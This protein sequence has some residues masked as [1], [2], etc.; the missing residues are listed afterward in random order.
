MKIRHAT[1]CPI[2]KSRAEM[3]RSNGRSGAKGERRFSFC[4]NLCDSLALR[5]IVFRP[6]HADS[7][8]V[9]TCAMAI[10]AMHC[11]ERRRSSPA[12]AGCPWHGSHERIS[13][14]DLV[15]RAEPPSRRVPTAGATPKANTSAVSVRL[16]ADYRLCARLSLSH[17]FSRWVGAGQALPCRFARSIISLPPRMS[18][19]PPPYRLSAGWPKLESKLN[20]RPT[21]RSGLGCRSKNSFSRGI[22]PIIKW[23]SQRGRGRIL[24]HFV[25]RQGCGSG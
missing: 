8:R 18:P 17:V 16:C 15:S 24:P 5:E 22:L 20:G 11:H 14:M 25:Y 10:L 21:G 23:G 9:A 2:L 6:L 7:R 19:D 13:G 12:R 4:A 1:N 3:Q